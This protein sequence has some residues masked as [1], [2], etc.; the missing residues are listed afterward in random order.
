MYYLGIDIAKHNHVA[1]LI[2]SEGGLVVKTIGFTNNAAGYRKLMGKIFAAI[3]DACKGDIFVGMEAT[4]HYWLSLFSAF[5]EDGFAVSVY[6]PFQIKSFRSA[7]SNRR[8]KTDVI[9]AVVIAN[10]IRAFGGGTTS[11]PC[12]ALLSLKQLTRYRSDLVQNVSAVKNQIVSIMDRIFPE[13]ASLLSNTF[14]ETGKAILQAAP[15]PALVL[16]FCEQGLLEIVHTASRGQLNQDFVDRL[17]AAAKESFGIKLTAKACTFELKQLVGAILF[18][19]GQVEGLDAEIKGIYSE[20]DEFLITIPGIGEVLAPAIFAE[21]GG[22]EKFSHP[23][24][25]IAFSGIDP[26]ANQ[27]GQKISG[28]EKISKRGSPYLRWAICKASFN[29][30]SNDPHLRQYYDR[31]KEE[32]KHHHVALAGVQ[33]KLLQIIWAVLKERR[34][35]RPY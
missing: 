14:G 21:I 20:L 4:G 2:D 6:N 19:E 3:P 17:K 22:I 9:D 13:F 23:G 1:S 15:T 10:Y 18:L 24:K 32:G 11:L 27:S 5:V 28:E 16:G 33:R 34:P 30:I 25:L 29:A 12:E 31:K 7:Y 26:S 8:Q 35:Y